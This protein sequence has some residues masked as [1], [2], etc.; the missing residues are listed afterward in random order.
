M[1]KPK[2]KHDRLRWI[3]ELLKIRVCTRDHKLGSLKPGHTIAK[4]VRGSYQ[5]HL[6]RRHEDRKK[7]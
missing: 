3:T 4:I 2:E 7:V 6:R 1:K 5:D